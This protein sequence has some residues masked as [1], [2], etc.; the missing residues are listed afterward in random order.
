[1]QCSVVVDVEL[2]PE[3]GIAQMEQAMVE[4]G[5]RAMRAALAQAVRSYED[6]H[7]ACPW[8]GEQPSRSEGTV[9]RRVLT[10]F[11][12]VVL[13][14]RRQ[15]CG[16]CG[17]RFR[18]ADG[19]L[20]ELNGG[21]VTPELAQAGA[22]AGASWPYVTAA[23]LLQRLCGAQI[24]AEEVRQLTGRLG[25]HEAVQQQEEA[26]RLLAPT[27]EDVRRE[28]DQQDQLACQTSTPRPPS[29][30]LVGL[31]G[32]WLASRDQAG[33]MEGK[34]AVV[35][36][37]SEPVG[38]HGRHRLTPRRYAATF[39]SSEQV[40]ALAYAAAVGLGGQDAEE[41]LVLGDGAAWIK[42]Q[43]ALHFPEAVGIL[44]WPHVARAVH[45]AIRAA[46]P[47]P[48]QRARRREL[49]QTIPDALWQGELDTALAALLAL[50]PPA[51]AEPIPVLEATIR[52]LRGQRD[53]LGNYAAWQEVGYPVG[54]GLV[55]RAVAIV[56]NWRMKR[57][58]MRWRRANASA[59]VALRVRELNATWETSATPSPPAA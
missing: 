39:A 4:A 48:A 49:H 28:R 12:R 9:R 58:G 14:L 21:N 6:A 31:D 22:L 46:C 24:S 20:R 5:R 52:Y 3:A 32:G 10:G 57:R 7:P 11:G 30:L 47:G 41:Q 25:R 29:R 23:R 18:P 53:W 50:R 27:A 43:A 59:V 19:C 45:Q 37:G 1:M 17:R 13:A 26:D 15:R 38:K 54:S 2:D 36:T 42:A 34:V 44:D 35:A 40:G 33:G 56:I 55:E 8:C 16:G 51:P